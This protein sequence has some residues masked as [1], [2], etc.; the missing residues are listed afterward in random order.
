M[1]SAVDFIRWGTFA[2]N[3]GQTW[4]GWF[5]WAFDGYHWSRMSALP[6]PDSPPGGTV[7]I[8]AEW[9]TPGALWVTFKSIG[10]QTVTFTPSVIIAPDKGV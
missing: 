7:Q 4:S 10:S 2:L 3:P 5:T 8:A 1:A 6:L 9:A